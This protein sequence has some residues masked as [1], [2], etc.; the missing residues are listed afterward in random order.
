M[1]TA[2][3]KTVA[4]PKTQGPDKN[5]LPNNQGIVD[6]VSG[7]DESPVID[8]RGFRGLGFISP[9]ALTGVTAIQVHVSNLKTGTFAVL[10]IPDFPVALKAYGTTFIAEWNYAK[11]VLVGALTGAGETP[12]NLS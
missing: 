4:L 12:Y 5:I 6:W 10:N 1:T 3:I 8:I 7:N 9:A 2:T 11:F